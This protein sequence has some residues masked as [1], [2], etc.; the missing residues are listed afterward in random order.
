MGEG[1]NMQ[2]VGGFSHESEHDLALM[3]SDCLENGGSSGP[4]YCRSND[5]ESGFGGGAG[6]I[7]N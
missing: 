5:S 2:I 3:V 4:N 7:I 1:D 6:I